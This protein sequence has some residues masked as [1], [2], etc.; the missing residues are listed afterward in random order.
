MNT[1]ELKLIHKN[2]VKKAKEQ[3]YLSLADEI[4]IRHWFVFYNHIRQHKL[5]RIESLKNTRKVL[6]TEILNKL[7][8]DM[9]LDI[10]FSPESFESGRLINTKKTWE[11]SHALSY[12]TLL[13]D[14]L[15]VSNG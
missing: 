14:N 5:E 15:E 6:H 12:C 1:K 7:S 4:F 11:V 2:I 3:E 9:K 10:V 8:Q 13:K